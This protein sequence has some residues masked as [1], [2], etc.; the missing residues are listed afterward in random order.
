MASDATSLRPYDDD[1]MIF[2]MSVWASIEDLTNFAYR[3]DHRAV[4]QQRRQWFE[5]MTTPFMC[6]WWIPAGHIPTV[7]EAKERLHHIEAHGETPFAFTFKHAFPAPDEFSPQRTQR[8]A[9]EIAELATCG[10]EE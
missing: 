7:Q 6:L 10:A 4:M 2:N 1:M 9:K 3:S 5:R 8:D